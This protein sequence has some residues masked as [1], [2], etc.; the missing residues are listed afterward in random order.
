MARILGL[1]YGRKRIGVAVTD[2][3]QMIASPLKTVPFH[4]ILPFLKDYVAKEDV[5]TMVVGWPLKLDGTEGEA[6]RL[7]EQFIRLLQRHFPKIA[8]KRHDERLT[9]VIAKQSLLKSGVKWQK[10]REKSRLDAISAA[11]ILRSFM[12][13]EAHKQANN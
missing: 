1:D 13:K 6:V 5:Q 2:A 9:S 12:E 11:L 8:I 4:E 10:R 3:L 7:V